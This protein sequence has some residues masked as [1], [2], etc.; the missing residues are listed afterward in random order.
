MTTPGRRAHVLACKARPFGTHNTEE[1][2]RKLADGKRVP[3]DMLL[4]LL[5]L[6]PE[7][8]LA[9]QTEKGPPFLRLPKFAPARFYLVH[10]GGSGLIDQVCACWPSAFFLNTSCTTRRSVSFPLY[11]CSVWTS[12]RTLS[13]RTCAC[14]VLLPRLFS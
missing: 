4:Q 1:C 7:G 12:A 14:S 10:M 11:A 8:G 6:M 3:A 13:A 9:L 2:R 5:C